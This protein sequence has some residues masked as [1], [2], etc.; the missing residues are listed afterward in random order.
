MRFRP[1]LLLL[2][3]LLSTLTA[4]QP[5][6]PAARP[7]QQ[8][9][10]V[11][12]EDD[13]GRPA[14]GVTLVIGQDHGDVFGFE[15]LSGVPEATSDQDGMAAFE[16][17]ANVPITHLFAEARVLAE[18]PIRCGLDVRLGI[19]SSVTLRLPPTGQ[20]RVLCYDLTERPLPSV[21]SVDLAI[22][23]NKRFFDRVVPKGAQQPEG[24][25]FA[26]V[27]L[28]QQLTATASVQDTHGAL[29]TEQP[30]PTRPGELVVIDLRLQQARLLTVRLLGL[31]GKPAQNT[32]LGGFLL[33]NLACTTVRLSTNQDGVLRYLLPEGFVGD[34]EAALHLARRG[35]GEFT[36]YLGAAR[37][38][39][40]EPWH[41]ERALGDVSLQPEPPVA[42]GRLVDP[43]G[44]PMPDV[45]L[46]TETSYLQG[47][48]RSTSGAD[49]WNHRTR[50][51]ANGAFTF[52]ELEPRAANLV[53]H[54]EG[55]V[56]LPDDTVVRAG[57]TAV[58]LTGARSGSA[59]V[60]LPGLPA[61]TKVHFVAFRR[62]L[63]ARGPGMDIGNGFQSTLTA[64][65]NGIEFTDLRPG[66]YDLHIGTSDL[67]GPVAKIEGFTVASG[68]R[69]DDPRL[70][71][72]DWQQ[73][74]HFVH[75]S[76][77]GSAELRIS[78]QLLL[79]EVASHGYSW[80]GFGSLEDAPRELLVPRGRKLTVFGPNC[81]SVVLDDPTGEVKI[82]LAPRPQVH[83]KLPAGVVLPPNLRL[84]LAAKAHPW[85]DTQVLVVTT[86][87]TSWHVRPDAT[88]AFTAKLSAPR[89]NGEYDEVWQGELVVPAGAGSHD[90]EL[91]IPAT[92]AQELRER[93]APPKK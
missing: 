28:G 80:H 71:V 38:P 49:S 54:A 44:K 68:K 78:A 55:K 42:Q 10:R 25:L 51:D 91:P 45:V 65:S 90:V 63:P 70:V 81:A 72:A 46:T 37:I 40:T 16:C 30:G 84:V 66:T 13:R 33:T 93:L 41:G 64:T 50:T 11:R 86:Q 79:G 17:D 82:A 6:P 88:G 57:D 32:A 67:T 60:E 2:P 34:T 69:C 48:Q 56:F 87:E 23:G 31:D 21:T 29:R 24:A 58:L 8:I 4:Q 47:A 75:L 5:V 61:G 85:L 19:L 89:G 43:D 26:R 22:T 77:E 52:R 18:P 27:A 35:G 1:A 20:V 39:M 92:T 62:R 76:F 59:V 83:L 7:A 12:V 53:I 36:E 74:L 14:P 73:H 15:P 3:V 9:F